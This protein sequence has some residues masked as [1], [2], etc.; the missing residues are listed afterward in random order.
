LYSAQLE[1][2]VRRQPHPGSSA[3]AAAANVVFM[4][5][6]FA[7]AGVGGV[8]GGLTGWL[9]AGNENAARDIWGLP[10][11]DGQTYLQPQML[12]GEEPL[13]IGD[14]EYRMHITQP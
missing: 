7:L 5:V 8:L 2:V 13:M 4:P 3:L 14:L 1:P 6:R 10:P 9:T 11:F 12:Y